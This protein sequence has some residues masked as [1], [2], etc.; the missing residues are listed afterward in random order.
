MGRINILRLVIMSPCWM[1]ISNF[2]NLV[3]Q[4]MKGNPFVYMDLPCHAIRERAHY[5]GNEVIPRD[6][7]KRQNTYLSKATT[8]SVHRH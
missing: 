6:K 2:Q 8:I 5:L 4:I 7:R 1:E 3:D